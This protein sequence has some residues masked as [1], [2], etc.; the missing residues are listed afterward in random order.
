MDLD[1]K[2]TYWTV[3]VRSE[4][5]LISEILP[6][7]PQ[8]LLALRMPLLAV[9]CRSDRETLAAP[10]SACYL[11]SPHLWPFSSCWNVSLSTF[12]FLWDHRICCPFRRVAARGTLASKTVTKVWRGEGN[13]LIFM[14]TPWFPFFSL[15]LF[16]SWLESL[17]IARGSL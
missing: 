14:V 16:R 6:S 10:R 3:A 2:V 15:A 7:H 12:D 4:M 1:D 9:G 17:P 11:G 13:H 8:A 5:V